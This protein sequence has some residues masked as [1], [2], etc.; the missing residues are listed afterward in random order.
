LSLRASLE[1]H[2][3]ADVILAT[4]G[5]DHDLPHIFHDAILEFGYK[6]IDLVRVLRIHRNTDIRRQPA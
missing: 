1:I 4:I 6:Y 2:N 3:A 5:H